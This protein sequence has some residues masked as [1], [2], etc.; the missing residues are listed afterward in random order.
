MQ[1]EV[2]RIFEAVER[3]D[4]AT[5]MTEIVRRLRL[6][7]QCFG[8]NACLITNLPQRDNAQW[9]GHILI[10]EWPKDWYEHYL[11]RGLFRADPCANLSRTESG[12]FL[13]SDVARTPLNA[14]SRN[15]MEEAGAFGLR[16]GLCVPIT[17]GSR[18][19]VV[20]IA[21]AEIDPSPLARCTA[22]ALARH[23]YFAAAKLV[24]G[25]DFRATDLSRREKEIL[26]WASQ[27]KTAWE[28]SQIL[29]IGETTVIT[30]VRNARQK[31]DTTNITHTVAEAL[32]R[33]HIEI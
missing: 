9:H 24:R 3:I 20:T 11:Q 14:A 16:E 26:R 21:G 10:N 27:G 7:L 28:I 12:P 19:S 17:R 4:K 8:Y 29:A 1:Y 13:W 15:V 30:H 23:S 6:G 33:G 2:M 18:S 5:T 25:C 32:R 22:H 31:L